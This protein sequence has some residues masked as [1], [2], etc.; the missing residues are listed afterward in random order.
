[1]STSSVCGAYA[2]RFPHGTE[3]RGRSP[4]PSS[5]IPFSIVNP[6][7]V[8]GSY[9]KP[10]LHC[11]TTRSDGRLDPRGLLERYRAK[12]YAAVVFTDHDRG[13]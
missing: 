4:N 6:Y 2:R 3:E 8:P 5:V 12:G 11:H 1:M 7:A 10:Q 13:P 9:R